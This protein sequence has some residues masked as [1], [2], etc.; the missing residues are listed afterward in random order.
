[1]RT[2]TF[3]EDVDA[4]VNQTSAPYVIDCG[5]DMR[6]LVQIVKTGTDGDLKVF[7]EEDV[8]NDIWTP[9]MDY[10]CSI[11]RDHFLIDDSPFAIRDSYFMSR[12]MRI[13]IEPNDNTTGTVTIKMNV[14][15]KSN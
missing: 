5:Q 14:K 13:R 12:N 11:V 6:W 1:M 8:D 4:T 7:I 9:L 2:H 3:F 10:D 15:T